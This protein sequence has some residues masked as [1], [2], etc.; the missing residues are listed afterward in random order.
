MIFLD[1]MYSI[2]LII[3]IPK[4]SISF[5]Q[6]LIK[7]IILYYIICIVNDFVSGD[8]NVIENLKLLLKI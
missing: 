6:P 3:R 8:I 2:T 4:G 7:H 5:S 1:T